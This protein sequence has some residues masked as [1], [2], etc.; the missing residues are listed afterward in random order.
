M[1][2][3]ILNYFIGETVPDSRILSM[4]CPLMAI[5]SIFGTFRLIGPGAT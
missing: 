2:F 5:R 1:P 4:C 3:L